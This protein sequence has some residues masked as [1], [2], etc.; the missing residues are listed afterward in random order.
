MRIA[1]VIRTHNEAPRLRLTLASLRS[2]AGLD[3]VVVVNDGSTDETADVV[4]EAGRH[5]PMAVVRHAAAR[6]RSAAANAGA[7]AASGDVLIFLDG[8]MPVGPGFVA[9]HRAAHGAAGVVI[10]RGET[11]HLRC[12]RML[13]DP[14]AGVGFPEHVARLARLGEG[15]RAAQ[16]VTMAEVVGDFAAVERRAQP[17]I[18]PGGGPRRLFESEMDALLSAPECPTLWAAASGSNQSVPREAFLETGGFDA[19]L[20]INEHR[21]LALRLV[22]RGAR[23]KPAV[24]ARSYHLTHRS[25][26]RD[27]LEHTDWETA[28]WKVHPTPA[29]AL[30]PVLWASLTEH[31]AISAERR[32]VSLP[33]LASRAAEAGVVAA[34][35]AAACR[36]LLGYPERLA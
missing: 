32:I 24:G 4:A 25:G 21:E 7:A 2:Q 29:V 19:L 33:D 23:L 17:A 26:W 13:R 11:W 27:P 15:E 3:E 35:S 6:G 5:L 31:P 34:D 36:A 9:A 30:L 8:D 12:T 14:D 28:F 16:R 18:Y 20:N 10:A 1:V 22:Q